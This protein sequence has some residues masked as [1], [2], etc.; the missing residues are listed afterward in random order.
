MFLKRILVFAITF[1]QVFFFGTNSIPNHVGLSFAGKHMQFCFLLLF[2]LYFMERYRNIY[3]DNSESLYMLMIDL[4]DNSE[5]LSL[6]DT[7]CHLIFFCS[8]L[9]V[10][11]YSIILMGHVEFLTFWI[12]LCLMLSF[13]LYTF[14]KC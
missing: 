13:D 8:C 5:Y 6:C 14:V 9:L 12:L 7:R 1:L 4:G 3:I 11:T 2:F 10:A